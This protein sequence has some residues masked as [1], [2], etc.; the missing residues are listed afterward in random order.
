MTT[1]KTAR[2]PSVMPPQQAPPPTEAATFPEDAPKQHVSE[3]LSSNGLSVLE[4]E[5]D[6]SSSTN[7]TLEAA[8]PFVGRRPK[9]PV[10]SNSQH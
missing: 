9:D 4:Y 3:A 1:P 2:S 10:S 7:Q 5:V 8:P 6:D